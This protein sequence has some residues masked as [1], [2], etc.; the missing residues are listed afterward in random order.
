MAS[1][2]AYSTGDDDEDGDVLDT[3]ASTVD[4]SNAVKIFSGPKEAPQQRLLRLKREVAELEQDL[5]TEEV[6]KLASQLSSHLAYGVHPRDDLVK[7]MKDHNTRQQQNTS[8]KAEEGNVVYELYGGSVPAS[9]PM[10]ERLLKLEQTV[11]GLGATAPLTQRVKEME[12]KVQRLNDKSIEE[13]ATRA[14]VI[15]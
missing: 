3:G 8:G 15:R 9:S 2:A 14:K 7:L 10:E 5:N 13:F 12:N 11:G 6:A 4:P 1:S